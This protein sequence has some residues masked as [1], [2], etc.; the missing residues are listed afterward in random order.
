M[1]KNWYAVYTKPNS[2]KKVAALLTKRKIENYC[3]LNRIVSYQ[4]NKKR[5]V[6]DPLFQSFV[7]V[8]ANDKEMEI[9]PKIPF[10]INFVYWLGKPAIIKDVEIENIQDFTNQ[11]TSIKLEKM[12]V[13]TNGLVK[14]ISEPHIDV[15]NNVFLLRNSHFKL[16]LPSLGY[17]MTAEIDKSSVDLFN[18]DFERNRMAL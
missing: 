1:K 12:N 15:N 16:L 9:I 2:E 7:F 4:G 18:R 10:I 13:N 3:P 11:H 5:V 14:V 6:F 8:F 17:V